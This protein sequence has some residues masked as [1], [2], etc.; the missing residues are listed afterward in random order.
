LNIA[1]SR[2][3]LPNQQREEFR[4]GFFTWFD[5]LWK[6]INLR[7][8][9]QPYSVGLFKYDIPTFDEESIREAVL[10]AVCHRDYRDGGSIWIRQ[11]PRRLEIESP[12]GLPDGITPENILTRQKPRNRRIAETLAKCGLV[13]RSGQGMDLMFKHS[14]RQG[15]PLPDMTGSDEHQVLLSL[16]GEVGDPRFL[17]FLE[18]IG[19]EQLRYFSTEDFL[20]IDL[21][22]HGEPLPDHLRERVNGLLDSGVI[23]RSGRGKV[24]LSRKFYAFLGEKG[25]HTRKKGLDRE[26]EKELLLKHL[27]AAG[28][29]GAPMAELLQVLKDR[30]RGH[31]QRLI[32]ELRAEDRAHVVG[33][34]RAARWFLGAATEAVNND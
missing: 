26:T 1:A 2:P 11:Y 25:V 32:N 19:E 28:S 13:E 18:Q 3:A 12:G 31:V 8:D 5:D 27:Q 30:S 33:P 9:I 4:Q 22:H 24:I 15:K 6:L 10:N 16:M 7:N 14:I 29:E 21:V 17:R 23:E 34:T 20:A